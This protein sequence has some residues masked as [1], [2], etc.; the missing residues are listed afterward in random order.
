MCWKMVAKRNAFSKCTAYLS[1]SEHCNVRNGMILILDIFVAYLRFE[2]NA[3]L[4][5]SYF[6]LWTAHIGTI[7]QKSP[8]VS[9][10]LIK[11]SS[12]LYRFQKLRVNGYY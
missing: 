5:F 2:M 10:S 1:L 12:V 6:R 8:N 9:T 3:N 4:D 11:L 7:F